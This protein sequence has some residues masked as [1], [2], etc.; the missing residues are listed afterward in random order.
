MPCCT[1]TER[2]SAGTRSS[3]MPP[4]PEGDG[5][6]H[7]RSALVAAGFQPGRRG[8]A[9][10]A[11]AG[12][13]SGES[14]NARRPVR[15]LA[16]T[17]LPGGRL[18]ETDLYSRSLIRL[19]EFSLFLSR[20]DHLGSEHKEN[21]KGNS[22]SMCCM[23]ISHLREFRIPAGFLPARRAVRS[24]EPSCWAE[25]APDFVPVIC[26]ELP[27]R[28]LPEALEVK[29]GGNTTNTDPVCPEPGWVTILR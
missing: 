4:T 5:R 18:G 21:W 10:Q 8:G 6:G 9:A 28:C 19:C 2:R 14:S 24:K 22:L 15:G 25:G 13:V 11:A 12:G 23:K 7:Q 29:P 20:H 3:A 16:V 27:A 17:W 1:W 26:A